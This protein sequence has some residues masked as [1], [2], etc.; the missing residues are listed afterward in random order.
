MRKQDKSNSFL[1]PQAENKAETKIQQKQQDLFAS[2]RRRLEVET[3]QSCNKGNSPNQQLRTAPSG[4][5]DC[6]LLHKMYNKC[7]KIIILQ[8]RVFIKFT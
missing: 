5:S 3:K 4:L 2:K 6:S 8:N 7:W 1:P